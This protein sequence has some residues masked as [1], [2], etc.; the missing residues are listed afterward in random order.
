VIGYEKKIDGNLYEFAL[1]D[2]E[3]LRLNFEEALL[4]V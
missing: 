3:S 1:Q 2:M 4:V